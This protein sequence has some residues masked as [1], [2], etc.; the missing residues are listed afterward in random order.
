[1]QPFVK[2]EIFFYVTPVKEK[3]GL[4]K[5]EV[6]GRFLGKHASLIFILAFR[7]YKDIK[8]YTLVD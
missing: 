5:G 1:M 4:S 3:L 7:D 2:D 8:M 6:K